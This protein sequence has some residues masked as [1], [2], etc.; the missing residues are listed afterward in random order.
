M[1]L[2]QDCVKHRPEVTGRRI[3]NLQY[4]SS[5][6]LLL[7]RLACLG[8]KPS[9]L[10][11]N[12]GLGGEVLQECDLLISEGAHLATIDGKVAQ[13]SVVLEQR[14]A[15][16]CANAAKIGCRPRYWVAV[17]VGVGR[18]DIGDLDDA[19]AAQQPVVRPGGP[20]RSLSKELG[21]L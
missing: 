8:Q 15:Q 11:S 10:H 20:V 19:F 1:G 17:Q 13:Y 2:L 3:D 18:S 4:L 12:H 5:S 16:Q 14:H 7:Q 9:I 6:G 21:E